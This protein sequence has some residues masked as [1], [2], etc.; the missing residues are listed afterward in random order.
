MKISHWSVARKLAAAFAAVTLTFLAALAAALLFS[1]AAQ[2]DWKHT[3]KW[4]AAVRAGA[5]QIGG[6][7]TQLAAQALYVATS[8]PRYKAE[9]ESGVAVANRASATISRLGDPV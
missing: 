8:Q 4:D 9:W 2:A 3:Q 7:Q 5:Q 6:I 1:D